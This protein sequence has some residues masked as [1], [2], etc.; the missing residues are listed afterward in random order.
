MAE[1]VEIPIKVNALVDEG[2]APLVL[3]MSQDLRVQ[4]LDSCQ[5]FPEKNIPAHVYFCASDIG[6]YEFCDEL[7]R[8]IRLAAETLDYHIG[9]LW[10]PGSDGPMAEIKINDPLDIPSLSSAISAWASAMALG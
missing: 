3:A 10:W 4:T 2:I 7:Q 9:V 6:I 5:G 1:H 8:G